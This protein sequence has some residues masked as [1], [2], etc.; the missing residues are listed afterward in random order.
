MG[1][2][3]AVV[4]TMLA[5]AASAQN[6]GMRAA[7]GE[8]VGFISFRGAT[9]RTDLPFRGGFEFTSAGGEV[10]GT[11]QWGSGAIQIGGLISGPDTMPSF[12]LTS[13][14]SNG[15]DIP[16]VAGG[17]EI[18]LT[19]ATCE[20]LEGTGV[21]IDVEM[22]GSADVSQIVW[23][24]V[25]R[26]ATFDPS[27]FFEAFEALQTTIGD[28]LKS[29]E[30][31]A[32]IAGGGIVGQIEPLLADAE[33]LA[34]ELGRVDVCGLEFYRSVIAAEVER[35]LDFV[36]TSPDVDV[37]TLGQVLL[38]AVRAGVIG[39]GAETI[40][41]AVEA[42]VQELLAERIA[43][44]IAASDPTELEVL[45]LIAEDLGLEDLADQVLSALVEMR[46]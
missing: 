18:L 22:M 45:G 26:G 2:A 28:L 4:M 39:S 37:F 32:V 33:T 38:M 21:N 24:A 46:Q 34:A 25:R 16:D 19:D 36:L 31:G 20:R 1:I 13:V 3:L 43:A 10:D 14:V 35:L 42:D 41:T 8:W 12:D 44:A 7:E 15:V 23:W 5:P 27:A 17:G 6:D 40:N 9:A 30:A 11:F 29:L